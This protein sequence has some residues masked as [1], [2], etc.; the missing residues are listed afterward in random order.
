L[1]TGL[2]IEKKVYDKSYTPFNA[3]SFTFN[4]LSFY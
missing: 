1:Y 4:Q 2:S 3:Y